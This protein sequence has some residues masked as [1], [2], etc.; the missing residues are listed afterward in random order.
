LSNAL[1]YTD[2][3]GTVEVTLGP[4]PKGACVR[5]RDTGTGI[6]ATEL[7]KI[8][9]KFYRASTAV[10]GKRRGTG[11]GLAFVKAVVNGQGGNVSVAS[12][13]GTGSTFTVEFPSADPPER[14]KRI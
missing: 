2:K 4:C 1:K 13:V 11:I 3:D 12:T 5:V 10:K 7:P 9:T 6:P 14:K 8:F